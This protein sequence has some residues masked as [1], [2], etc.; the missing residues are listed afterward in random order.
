MAI[1]WKYLSDAYRF[2]IQSQGYNKKIKAI[3]GVGSIVLK[4]VM[5]VYSL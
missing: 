3:L 2:I 4:T 1:M 5:V